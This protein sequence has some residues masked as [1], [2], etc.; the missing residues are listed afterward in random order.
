MALVTTT[1]KGQREAKLG[2]SVSLSPCPPCVLLPTL[3]APDRKDW[4]TRLPR[5]RHFSDT[6]G[7]Y[8][9][10]NYWLKTS[11]SATCLRAGVNHRAAIKAALTSSHRPPGAPTGRA[12][13]SRPVPKEGSP[14]FPFGGP[15]TAE[16]YLFL[17]NH[18]GVPPLVKGTAG[19][20]HG[21]MIYI[22]LL[23]TRGSPGRRGIL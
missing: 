23:F 16:D 21:H 4:H 18:F 9:R 15:R 13:S 6:Q 12:A 17:I 8:M 14:A 20:W 2:S 22:Q 5:K 11:P 1:K 7:P 10:D 3:P 19:E